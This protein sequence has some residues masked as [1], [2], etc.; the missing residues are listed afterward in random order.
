MPIVRQAILL[1]RGACIPCSQ[2]QIEAGEGADAPDQSRV[3]VVS[4]HFLS[5]RLNRDENRLSCWTSQQI[6]SQRDDPP[7]HAR[8]S[9]MAYA[10]HPVEIQQRNPHTVPSQGA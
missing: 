4:F 6:G 10:L 5:L 2:L 3:R 7:L 8:W 1:S 9:A